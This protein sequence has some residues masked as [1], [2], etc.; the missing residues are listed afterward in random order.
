MI[1]GRVPDPEQDAAGVTFAGPDAA[2]CENTMWASPR[3]SEAVGFRAVTT[4]EDGRIRFKERREK[5][6]QPPTPAGGRVPETR[7]Q[8]SDWKM[9][10]RR[11]AVCKGVG[12]PPTPRVCVHACGK[13][14]QVGSV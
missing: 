10:A 9:E 1:L 7:A 2:V 3:F 5:E 4:R 6:K 13:A 11:F 8:V 14:V 12:A